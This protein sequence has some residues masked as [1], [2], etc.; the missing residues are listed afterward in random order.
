MSNEIFGRY[1]VVTGWGTNDLEVS[2]Q[3]WLV[4]GWVLQ[5]GVSVTEARLDMEGN[6]DPNGTYRTLYAQ[7]VF[8]P[9]PIVPLPDKL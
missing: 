1:K 8:D 2:V 4:Q 7:A 3:Y 6:P 9:T 5:G